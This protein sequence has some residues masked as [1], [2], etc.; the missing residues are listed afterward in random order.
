VVT[1][2]RSSALA[3]TGSLQPRRAEQDHVQALLAKYEE[4]EGQAHTGRGGMGPAQKASNTGHRASTCDAE[5]DEDDEG[6][7]DSVA[8]VS[9]SEPESWGGEVWEEDAVR[10]VSGSYLRFSKR[11][12]LCPDQVVR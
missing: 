8:S 12:A 3:C 1:R 10:G 2:C 9:V 6:G 5:S 4:E 11:L 7:A